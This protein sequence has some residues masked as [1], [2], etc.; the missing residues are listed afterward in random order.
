MSPYQR[1]DSGDIVAASPTRHFRFIFDP[2]S[3][4]A[5]GSEKVISLE[6]FFERVRRLENSFFVELLSPNMLV[7]HYNFERYQ[8]EIAWFEPTPP[9]WEPPESSSHKEFFS[10][11]YIGNSYNTACAL[12]LLDMSAYCQAD[13]IV[14]NNEILLKYCYLIYARFR[15]RIISPGDLFDTLEIISHGHS[16]FYSV[17]NTIDYLNADVFYQLSHYKCA[18]YFKWLDGSLRGNIHP[19]LESILRSALLNRYPYILFSRDMVK[20]YEFQEDYYYRREVK[21]SYNLTVGYYLNN[22]MLL[23]WG[24]LDHLTVIAKYRFGLHIDERDCSINNKK[25]WNETEPYHRG[26]FSFI[27]S[28]KIQK[29]LAMMAD[30]RHH[31]AH[32]TIKVPSELLEEGSEPKL[33]DEEIAEILREE[34]RS[35]YYFFPERMLAME[36]QNIAIWKINKMKVLAQRMI[37]IHRRDGTA[38]MIDPVLAVDHNL[39]RL[40]AII[41]AFMC[42]LFNTDS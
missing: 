5:L 18:R 13:G 27:Y 2:Q 23:L 12:Y 35:A 42:A 38:Y 39:E 1:V 3:V 31:A 30:M 4:S 28:I 15:I 20:F 24:M 16:I 40:N 7:E 21:R 41:D 9:D 17:T 25:F 8:H 14:T 19:E 6:K 22:F 11:N 33:S 26:L 37:Y 10:E 32:K 36:S 34:H 29:W